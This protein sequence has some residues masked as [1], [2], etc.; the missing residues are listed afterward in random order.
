M[1]TAFMDKGEG[2]EKEI[3]SFLLYKGNI[4]KIKVRDIKYSVSDCGDNIDGT[5]QMFSAL[6][7]YE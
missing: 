1:N 7:M 3:N 2:L 5:N 6:I 4:L